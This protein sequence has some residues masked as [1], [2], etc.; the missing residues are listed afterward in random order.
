MDCNSQLYI[1]MGIRIGIKSETS[2]PC[3]NE[4]MLL[5]LICNFTSFTGH[6]PKWDGTNGT[7]RSIQGTSISIPFSNKQER[8]IKKISTVGDSF[9]TTGAMRGY[10]IQ[11]RMGV[12]Q[13]V[14]KACFKKVEKRL[15]IKKIAPKLLLLCVT[16]SPIQY[17]FRAGAKAIRYIV[18]IA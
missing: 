13:L 2:S 18:N 16:R 7:H 12:M 9:L 14:C 15:L 11:V 3:H 17:D 1:N 4:C 10:I 8:I 6:R 5:L